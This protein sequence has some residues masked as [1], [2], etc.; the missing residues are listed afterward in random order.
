MGRQ[1]R[2]QSDTALVLGL[3]VARGVPYTHL[4]VTDALPRDPI[5]KPADE[6][7]LRPA[8]LDLVVNGERQSLVVGTL[9]E[10][11]VALG[12]GEQKVATALNGMFVAAYRRAETELTDGDRIEIVAPRQGG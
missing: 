1:P 12:Y 8:A 7:M 11:L 10:A 2:S 6:T 5:V 9:Q 3:E 4:P